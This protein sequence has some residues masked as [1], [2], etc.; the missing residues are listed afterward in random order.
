M[1]KPT[2]ERS[3]DASIKDGTAYAVMAGLGETSYVGA[4][5]LFLEASPSQVA[6]LVTIPLF[7][8]SCA[9]L[10]TPILI[11]RTGRRKPLFVGGSLVQALAWIPMGGALFLPAPWGFWTLFAG[12][13]LFFA[14]LHFTVPAWTSVM[15]DLVPARERGRFFGRR[16]SL[17]FLLQLMAMIV[18]GAGLAIY[19]GAGHE[20]LGYAV[21]FSG[22]FVARLLSVWYLNRM[23]EP[24]YVSRA[25]DKFTLWQFL[26]RLP[27][28]NFAKFVI[29]VSC[30][31]ASAHF[32]GALFIPYWRDQLQYSY[33][34]LM[35]VT[36]MIV[37]TMIVALPFWGRV[38]DRYGNKKVLKVTAFGIA[39]LPALWL[40]SGHI[41]WACVLQV[42][43][44]I[45]WSGFNQSVSNF[46]FDAV[47][48]PKRARCTAYMQLLMN[49]GVLVGGVA[50]A[51][52]IKAMPVDL[53]FATLPYPFWGLLILSC[54][55]RFATLLF[56][57][58]RFR[59]VREV[60]QIGT[61]RMLVQS[62]REAA[63][64]AVDLVA[65]FVRS[66][67]EEEERAGVRS[68]SAGGP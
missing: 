35:T 38:A 37:L 31:N 12:F 43:S 66:D 46:L 20:K 32:A 57:I 48:P 40:V 41:A 23:E 22:A 19:K 53:G 50:G 36:S 29:F 54:L 34:E 10:L 65:G 61:A 44:G 55:F 18:S 3:L 2:V 13:V 9:Q 28:S 59:E 17:C 63:E 39:T 1:E 67:N 68:D 5:A 42:W 49:L 47:S 7:L 4:C 11:E 14:A 60:P 25:Q 21:V 52:A 51:F 58:P 62:T 6:L 24:P 33:V 8:G 16:S 15:G 56:F 45:A 26:A 27:E 64:S 30:M